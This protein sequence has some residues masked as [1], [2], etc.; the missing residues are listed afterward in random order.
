[1]R[2]D[3]N[4]LHLRAIT[5]IAPGCMASVFLFNYIA[6]QSAQTRCA[7][8]CCAVVPLATG[9]VCCLGVAF[10]VRAISYPQGRSSPVRM[11]IPV[12]GGIVLGT[13]AA[14]VISPCACEVMCRVNHVMSGVCVFPSQV[15]LPGLLFTSISSSVAFAYVFCREG[16]LQP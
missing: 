1:M 16:T 8:L 13:T 5:G 6:G 14:W 3:I 15:I 4:K 11:D 10:A 12:L 2:V 7:L 9:A